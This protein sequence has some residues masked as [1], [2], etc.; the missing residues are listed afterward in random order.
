M[1]DDNHLHINRA[2]PLIDWL[3]GSLQSIQS[4]TVT[5][6][7]ANEPAARVTSNAGRIAVDLLRPDTF[8]DPEDDTGLFDKLK[9]AAEFAQK[10]SDKGITLSFLRKGKEAVRLGKDANPTLSKLVTRSD[11]IQLTSIGQ[12]AKLRRDFKAG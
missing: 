10:L 5:V 7:L 3:A 1:L 9:T 12:F 11:N 4:G 8:R 6:A 2:D